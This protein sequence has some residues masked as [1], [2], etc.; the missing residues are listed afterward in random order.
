[1]FKVDNDNLVIEEGQEHDFY[2]EGTWY[3]AYTRLYGDGSQDI[4]VHSRN[5]PTSDVKDKVY[6]YAWK[7]F[8]EQGF[9]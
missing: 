6:E 8:E 7:L 5:N 1:M 3:I 4:E 9:I 2:L